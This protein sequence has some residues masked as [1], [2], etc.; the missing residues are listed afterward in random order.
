MRR[1]ISV[2]IPNIR[3]PKRKH[4]QKQCHKNT[5]DYKKISKSKYKSNKTEINNKSIPLNFTNWSITSKIISMASILVL[6][7]I[8]VL[9]NDNILIK[10]ITKNDIN[11]I[12]ENESLAQKCTINE[13]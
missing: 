3:I 4:F 9:V 13:L 7:I 1:L 6:S 12:H 8:L 2:L 10:E 11:L 5:T